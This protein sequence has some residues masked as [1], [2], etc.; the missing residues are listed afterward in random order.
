ML[1]GAFLDDSLRGVIEVLLLDLLL[2]LTKARLVRF[3]LGDMEDLKEEF[4]LGL[5]EAHLAHLEESLM[6]LN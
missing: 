5:S 2:W 3:L 6:A 1:T 4:F